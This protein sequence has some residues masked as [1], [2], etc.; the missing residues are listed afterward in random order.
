MK[1]DNKIILLGVTGG[2][3]AYKA[4]EL[5]RLLV[6]QHAIVNVVMTANAERFVGKMSFQALSGN[7]VLSDTFDLAAG[8]EIKHISVPDDA[9]IAVVAPATADFIGKVAHGI[10]DDMLTTMMLAMTGPVLIAPSMNVH[11]YGNRIV[12][13]NIRRLKQYGYHFME[14]GEGWLA[15]GYEGKGRLADPEQIMDET[16]LLLTKKDLKNR[17]VLVTAGPT[18]EYLDPVRFISNPSSGKMG[19]AIARAARMRGARV[20]LVSGK[21]TLKPPYGVDFIEIESARQ[22]LEQVSSLFKKMDAIVMTS[23]VSDFAPSQKSAQKIK[24]TSQFLD[25]RLDRTPDI[26]SHIAKDKGRRVIVGFAA[27]TDN[28][29]QYAKEKLRRK[30]MDMIV[31]NDVTDRDSGFGVDTN[32]ALLIFKDGT[33]QDLPVMQK[34][35]LANVIL[36]RLSL[37]IT[38]RK[39]GK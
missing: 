31:A 20:T 25:I 26:L 13:D 19:Y 21:V 39:A 23:A 9:D 35:V 10:A 34:S 38:G 17:K 7:P 37:L 3:A 24:K 14:P 4:L 18:R 30:H 22:M 2:I 8:A 36:D 11:M 5:V 27:E 12:Q 6:K 1:L 16:E 29:Q 32:K 15:C 33:M 28:L